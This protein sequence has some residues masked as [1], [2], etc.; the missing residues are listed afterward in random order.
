MF[1]NFDNDDNVINSQLITTT[2]KAT[3]QYHCN[4]AGSKRSPSLIDKQ[5]SYLIIIA[6]QKTHH[7]T[8]INRTFVEKS[9]K[10]HILDAVSFFLMSPILILIEYLLTLFISL[11]FISQSFSP[12][13]HS[14]SFLLL[15]HY[16]YSP[17]P[18]HY[19]YY[20][21]CSNNRHQVDCVKS[22]AR[23]T[24]LRPYPFL[25]I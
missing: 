22:L 6:L 12:V 19:Y 8:F 18:F 17:F 5:Q 20:Y 14:S 7:T 21:R 1:C 16:L 24:N 25:A 11:I 23:L 2:T 13:V 15:M 4:I 9:N 3:H 10:W